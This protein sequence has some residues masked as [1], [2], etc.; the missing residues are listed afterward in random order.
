M[1]ELTDKCFVKLGVLGEF[2]RQNGISIRDRNDPGETSKLA[3]RYFHQQGVFGGDVG[4]ITIF[5]RLGLE[6]QHTYVHD[7]EGN[8]I[9]SGRQDDFLRTIGW[10]Y[11]SVSVRVVGR[12]DFNPS[13]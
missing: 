4:A 12:Q 1:S 8:L 2:A 5:R 13:E 7:R 10:P 3:A 9:S 6:A 11:E